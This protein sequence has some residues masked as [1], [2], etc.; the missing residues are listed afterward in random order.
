MT[1]ISNYTSLG[2]IMSSPQR[3]GTRPEASRDTIREGSSLEL[4]LLTSDIVPRIVLLWGDIGIL[5]G[6][7]CGRYME[8]DGS[9]IHIHSRHLAVRLEVAC[10][11]QLNH[12]YS[13][14]CTKEPNFIYSGL[15]K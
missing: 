4:L 6:S 12:S 1:L 2:C 9:A 14:A 3:T 15:S 10:R 5:C 13:H 11:F 8:L 7:I